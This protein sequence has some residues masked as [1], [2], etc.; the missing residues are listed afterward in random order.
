MGQSQTFFGKTK[1]F[2]RWSVII[3]ANVAI[4]FVVGISTIRESYRDWSVDKE[5]RD[6]QQQVDSLEGK[7]L[8][9]TG[10]IGQLQSTDVIDKEARARLGMQKPGER[11]AIIRESG[12]STEARALAEQPRD[13][14]AP[15]A[16]TSN[17]EKWFTY[18]FG[19]K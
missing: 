17:P 2:A 5:I 14:H 16:D 11:V 7:R 13:E 9:V 12:A 18:F 8:N 4:L 10:L 6:L 1:R 15:R 19:G 3:A